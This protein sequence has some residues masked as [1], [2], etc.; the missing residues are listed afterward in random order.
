MLSFGCIVMNTAIMYFTSHAIEIYVGD[1]IGKVEQLLIIILIEHIIIGIKVLLAVLIKDVP[2]WV[3][4]EE[5]QQD[6]RLDA[7]YKTL[8]DKKDEYIKKGGV[9]LKD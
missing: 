5:Q 2:E 4:K 3:T 1:R 9:V 6:A 8:E 7:L